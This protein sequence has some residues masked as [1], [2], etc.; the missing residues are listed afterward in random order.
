MNTKLR[1]AAL[2]A[3]VA[4]GAL[5]GCRTSVNT[6]DPAN[7]TGKPDPEAMKHAITDPSLSDAV[8]PVFYNKGKT[9][10][11]FTVVQ[12]QVQNQTRDVARVNY[13]VEWFDTNGLLSGATAQ[14]TPLVI[15][16]GQIKT[17]Q[18]TAPADNFVDA[19]IAFQESKN[20]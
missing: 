3:L 7:P 4:A 20:N 6:V 19:R 13:K 12:L 2:A 18:A 17:I 1:I 8:V 9:P 10:G 11:G 16:A 14:V 5:A 15:E